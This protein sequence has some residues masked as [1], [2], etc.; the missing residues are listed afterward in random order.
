MARASFVIQMGVAA[1]SFL[2]MQKAALACYECIPA[3]GEICL[4]VDSG[5]C[6]TNVKISAADGAYAYVMTY[7]QNAFPPTIPNDSLSSFLLGDKTKLT[8]CS[9]WHYQSYCHTYA[10][11]DSNSAIGNQSVGWMPSSN[12][13]PG[14]DASLVVC[15]DW[16]SSYWADVL[17]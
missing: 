17:P 13:W 10:R 12:V 15:N 11:D 5:Y 3:A 14:C 4:Y 6:G 16:T 8:V 2:G 1:V 7:P 9:D